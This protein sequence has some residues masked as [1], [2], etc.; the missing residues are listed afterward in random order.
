VYSILISIVVGIVVGVAYTLLGFWK[1]WAMGIIL[2]VVV[3]L[4]VFVLLSRWLA[5]RFE[6][7]FL[8]AQKQLQ[9][10]SHQLA[11]STLEKLLP[12]A[13]WQVMLEGQI[14]AQMGILAHALEDEKRA[15]GYLEKAALR[16][17]DAQMALA[18]IHFRRKDYTRAYQVMDTAIRAS[19]KQIMPYHVYAWMLGKQ[20]E[21]DKAISELQRCLKVEPSNESTKDNLLRLQNDRKL[22]MKRFGLPWYALRLERPPAS[23][24]QQAPGSSHRGLR[25]KHRREGRRR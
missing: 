21:R 22:N 24:R 3:G 6:P 10:G 17:P 13:R 9:A 25:G 12:L 15:L 20:G 4:T 5:K 1:T 16:S 18:A 11:I 19:K 2:A 14:Y 8:Q 23:M 7:R